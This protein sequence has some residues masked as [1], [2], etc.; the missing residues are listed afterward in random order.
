MSK[1][2][3]TKELVEKV[4]SYL[5]DDKYSALTYG[6]V[7]ILCEISASTVSRIKNG[8]Y[9]C[10]LTPVKK[11][12]K[13]VNGVD[14][15]IDY[16]TLDHLMKCEYAVN[17]ILKNSILSTGYDGGLFIDYKVIYGILRA[18][19]PVETE[20]RLQELREEGK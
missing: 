14:V 6:E 20:K 16:D 9:D 15:H 13:P 3:V 1:D 4:K 12:V 17:A 11:E 10:L 5:S 19:V 8:N 18:Y 7:G 2:L